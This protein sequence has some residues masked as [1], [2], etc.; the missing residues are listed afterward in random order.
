MRPA[1]SGAEKGS[2]TLMAPPTGPPPRT[3]PQVSLKPLGQVLPDLDLDES[4]AG[5][6]NLPAQ[7][8]DALSEAVLR[9]IDLFRMADFQGDGSISHKEFAITLR[10]LGL[11]VS[12]AE[13]KQIFDSFD[14]NGDGTVAYEELHRM[15]AR[16]QSRTLSITRSKAPT[17]RKLEM[18]GTL[19]A[20][21]ELADAEVT[22]ALR[23]EYVKIPLVQDDGG[24]S[25]TFD[26]WVALGGDQSG[27]GTW[28]PSSKLAVLTNPLRGGPGYPTKE[29]RVSKGKLTREFVEAGWNVLCYEG[30]GLTGDGDGTEQ[31]AHL[32]SVFAWLSTDRKLQYCR[33]ALVAQGTGASAVLKAA[34]GSPEVFETQLRVFAAAQMSGSETLE[35]DV[36]AVYAPAWR[37]PTLFAHHAELSPEAPMLSSTVQATLQENGIPTEMVAVPPDYPTYTPRRIL[38]ASRFFG[39]YPEGLMEFFERHI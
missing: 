9:G 17:G 16:T 15:L 27:Q 12:K 26:A 22:H 32:R 38:Q 37:V 29:T 13:M 19:R 3:A 4:S 11:E 28:R 7:L 18:F 31:V 6:R 36:S 25:S 1:S 14:L 35:A 24:V 20:Y 34:A 33:V 2:R 8:R 30:H 21:V 5:L 23:T 10:E 39:D